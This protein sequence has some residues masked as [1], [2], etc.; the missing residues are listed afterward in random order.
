M[1]GQERW[2][3][4]EELESRRVQTRSRFGYWGFPGFQAWPLHSALSSDLPYVS[5]TTP[6]YLLF[7]MSLRLACSL[8]RIVQRPS[9]GLAS[10]SLR[11][12]FAAVPPTPTPELP[13]ADQKVNALNPTQTAA[14]RLSSL[15]S[16]PCSLIL[17]FTEVHVELT[18]PPFL[19]SCSSSSPPLDRSLQT[20]RPQHQPAPQSPKSSS[21]PTKR[22]P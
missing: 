16:N 21:T 13:A 2:R 3:A 19:G 9:A 12:S 5:T 6:P 10:S 20:L 17:V 1:R 18:N 8:G 15:L 11:R 4:E 22:R 14:S 7:S